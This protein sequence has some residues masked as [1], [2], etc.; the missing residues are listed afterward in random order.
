M[1]IFAFIFMAVRCENSLPFVED[2]F[3]ES[4]TQFPA[5]LEGVLKHQIHSLYA[6][7]FFGRRYSEN[8]FS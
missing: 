1:G 7:E 5:Q 4:V 2:G 6:E 8:E 3:L